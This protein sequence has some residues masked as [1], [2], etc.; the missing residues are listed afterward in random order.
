MFHVELKQ[1]ISISD[2]MI[3]ILQALAQD[4]RKIKRQLGFT[5]TYIPSI[6]YVGTRCRDPFIRREAI[7]VLRSFHRTEDQWDSFLVTDIT[8]FIT[9]LEVRATSEPVESSADVPTSARVQLMSAGYYRIDHSTK[10]IKV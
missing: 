1:I 5:P 10:N 3:K 8:E 6:G 7:T 2:K 4:D 9:K